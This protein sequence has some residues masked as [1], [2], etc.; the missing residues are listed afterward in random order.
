[1]PSARLRSVATKIGLVVFGLAA[2][3]IA[4]ELV[5][6]TGAWY[7]RLRGQTAAQWTGGSRRVICVGDS[8]TYG[9]W[10]ERSQAYPA[11][12]QQRWDAQAGLPP[13]EVLNLGVPGT[14]SSKLRKGFD[15]ILHSFAP[16]LI[17][18]MIGGNDSWTVP[19]QLEDS[20]ETAL[21]RWWSRSRVFRLL[22]MVRR[23]VLN[24][25]PPVSVE[26]VPPGQPRPKGVVHVGDEEIDLAFTERGSEPADW[27]ITLRANLDAMIARARA[28]GAEPVLVTYPSKYLQY[29]TAN[30]AMRATARK[31]GTPL[32]DVAAAMAAA[33]PNEDCPDLLLP[34]YHATARGNEIVSETVARGLRTMLD[35]KR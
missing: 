13:I 6:Q 10:L 5:L 31:T 33:C 3:L 17:L 34:D 20:S 11:Q 26:F 8:N 32:L 19:V 9:L 14:N 29:G 28:H 25:N 24:R 16:D 30:A 1:M 21:Q 22:Y 7:L 23:A 12:L 35:G 15:Q 27:A 4:T 2:A 18:I